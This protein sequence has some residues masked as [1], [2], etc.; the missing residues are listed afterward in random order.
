MYLGKKNSDTI[1][2]RENL[3]RDDNKHEWKYNDGYE[4]R[5]NEEI[6]P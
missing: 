6:K 2:Y 5:R 3:Y 1:N 4:Y